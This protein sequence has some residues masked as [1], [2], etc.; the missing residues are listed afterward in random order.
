MNRKLKQCFTLVFALAAL[1]SGVCEAA[2]K[3][4]KY[5]SI[6]RDATVFRDLNGNEAL[7]VGEPTAATKIDGSFPAPKGK[8]GKL[9]LQGGFDIVTGARNSRVVQLDGTA[10]GPNGKR[11]PGSKDADL[12]WPKYAGSG[13]INMVTNILDKL[14]SGQTGVP[15]A[16]E[17][18]KNALVLDQWLNCVGG[19]CGDTTPNAKLNP[20]KLSAVNRQMWLAQGQ[21]TV[22][23]DFILGIAQ[24]VQGGLP[25]PDQDPILSLAG[26]ISYVY[27]A[28][29]GQGANLVDST[30]V[31][32]LL[33]YGL[34]SMQIRHI[35]PANPPYKVWLGQVVA[36][37]G[38]LNNEFAKAVSVRNET[39]EQYQ[40][41]QKIARRAAQDLT[42]QLD[43][44]ALSAC[45][46]GDGLQR[47]IA[48]PTLTDCASAA[49][50]LPD[51]STETRTQSCPPGQ[52]GAIAQTCTWICPNQTG[53]P[54]Q[55]CIDTS[56]TCSG[57]SGNRPPVANGQALTVAAGVAQ[58]ITLSASDADRDTL[59]YK[60]VNSVNHGNL[61]G[62]PPNLFYT[63]NSNYIGTD[64]FTFQ[65]NDGKA[66]SNLATVTITV[67]SLNRA[68]VASGLTVS[69]VSGVAKTIALVATDE[70]R[71]AL[72]YSVVGAPSH[73]T[74]SGAAPNL[75]YTAAQGYSGAD[76]FTFKANDG[77]LDSN[78]A[79]VS[80][81]VA[82]PAVTVQEP[83]MVRLPGG[84]YEMGS[85]LGEANRCDCESPHTVTVQAFGI[86]KYEVTQGQWKSVMET[87]PAN[88][89]TCGDD[90][91][92]ENVSWNDVQQYIARL[93]QLTGKRY[94][95][96][97]EAEWEYAARGGTTTAYYWGDNAAAACPYANIYDLD[98]DAAFQFSSTQGV[99]P[100]NCSDG[101]LVTAP[102]GRLQPNAFGLYDMLGNVL[103]WTCS[104]VSNPYD[105]SES[106]CGN[107]SDVFRVDR[108]GSIASDL[109]GARAASRYADD[110]NT[111]IF[112]LGF[113]IAH[114]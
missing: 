104:A 105:G 101:F 3:A 91:P 113:R 48:D 76:S 64:S 78:I 22:L 69:A 28:K 20:R 72:S 74:L 13:A 2:P 40:A 83:V 66:N 106:V 63:A 96:P 75:V 44:D 54:V 39:F 35:D 1:S 37:A 81:T 85:P 70:D 50:K 67:K 65:A 49:C 110:P 100:Y 4:K 52:T 94:R 98:A 109:G 9:F 93:N 29:R 95:L 55:S 11:A 38:E 46:T 45:Y 103:E 33:D 73:G 18:A 53:S 34:R 112:F 31:R 89:A 32:D 114:D 43:L 59:S 30:D 99:T 19:N 42:D 111:Q 10:Q 87:N 97:T 27:V 84:A 68:P 47:R 41:L 7:D 80:I 24:R 86:G 60:V 61:S 71:D 51:P 82:L 57:G 92:I 77:K 5:T 15:L 26:A 79:T 25:F 21:L 58:L 108:G 88:Y 102:V 16:D 12:D 62:T 90:C 107:G 6:F 56:N 17:S 8:S 23:S 36:V 14:T